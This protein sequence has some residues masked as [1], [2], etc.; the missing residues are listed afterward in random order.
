MG[1]QFYFLSKNKAFFFFTMSEAE[2]EKKS[3][4]NGT[5]DTVHHF[6]NISLGGSTTERSGALKMNA[7]ALAW[8]SKGGKQEA[9]TGKDVR[10]ATWLPIGRYFQLKLGVKGGSTIKFD[11]FRQ[12]DF[13]FLEKF[14]KE[15]YKVTVKRENTTLRG[16]NWGQAEIVGETLTFDVEGERAF[17]LPLTEVANCALQTGVRANKSKSEVSLELQQTAGQSDADALVELRL[18]V[19]PTKGERDEDDDGD[20]DEEEGETPAQAFCAKVLD[21]VSAHDAVNARAIAS[22]PQVPIVA[23]RNKFDVEFYP[24]YLHMVSSARSFKIPYQNVTKVFLLLKPDGRHF[25]FVVS[26]DPPLLQGH[27][28]YPHVVM[29]LARDD[30][31]ELDIT[32]D[33]TLKD[34]YGSQLDETLSGSLVQCMTKMFQVMTGKKATTTGSFK[35]ATAG[36][37]V[38]EEVKTEDGKIQPITRK[39]FSTAIRCAHKGNSGL[40]Y[41]L[42]KSFFFIYKPAT[43]VRHDEIA[44]IEFSRVSKD[45][46]STSQR[47]FDITLNLKNGDSLAFSG[48]PRNEFKP[49]FKFVNDKGLKIINLDAEA[50]EGHSRQKFEELSDDDDDDQFDDEDESSDEEFQFKGEDEHVP[51]E[52]ETPPESVENSEDDDDDDDDDDDADKSPKKSKKKKRAASQSPSG[53][54]RAKKAKT[55][56]E[57]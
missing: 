15:N 57:D 38:S 55:E 48:I 11:G 39:V 25:V 16:W 24:S 33:A 18:Y 31:V 32:L 7:D 5:E 42:E 19:P 44:A 30:N 1:T 17:E 51:E 10:S 41:P 29:H 52:F 47:N 22:F 14:I 49:L 40:L 37:V 56:V 20:D 46:G 27:V 43:Y 2:T 45:T 21:V 26:L 28:A 9:V 4:S 23:P 13:E 53:S 8:Q 50:D 35:S 34:K 6:G 54:E 12:Q 36:H 3:T